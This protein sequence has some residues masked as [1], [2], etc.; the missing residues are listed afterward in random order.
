M[1]AYIEFLGLPGTGKT[2]VYRRLSRE[3]AALKLPFNSVE[4]RAFAVL[5][6]S[7]H[8]ALRARLLALIPRKYIFPLLRQPPSTLAGRKFDAFQKFST[9]HRDFSEA[10]FEAEG[11]RISPIR[12]GDIYLLGMMMEIIW[13][14]QMALDNPGYLKFLLRDEGFSQRAISLY[15]YHTDPLDHLERNARAYFSTMP[16]PDAVV[17]TTTSSLDIAKARLEKRGYPYRMRML[18]ADGREKAFVR[19]G[20]I[21]E[22]GTE[23][24]R[25]RGGRIVEIENDD[26][27]D[28]DRSLRAFVAELAAR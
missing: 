24:L 8:S 15:G 3:L 18:T 23:V 5:L 9:L 14:H 13:S 22:I 26:A 17:V 27:G 21:V 10:I 2:H 16:L 25:Q 6:R 7:E 28:I 19:M 20:R 4:A 1:P 12:N 11:S